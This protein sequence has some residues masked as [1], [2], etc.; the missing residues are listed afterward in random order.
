MQ[1]QRVFRLPMAAE[2]AEERLYRQQ[3]ENRSRSDQWV[4]VCRRS[5]KVT[6]TGSDNSDPSWGGEAATY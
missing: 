3:E 1:I 5:T 4:L 6:T 2:I